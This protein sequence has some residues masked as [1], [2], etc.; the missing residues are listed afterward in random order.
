[1]S[2]ADRLSFL[3]KCF[4]NPTGG[5][6]NTAH[7]QSKLIAWTLL[8][9]ILFS[10]VT[11]FVVS[12]FNPHNDPVCNRYIIFI[13]GL[14]AFFIFAYILNCKGHY[15]ISSTI[16]VISASIAPWVSLY[17]DP[18]IFA[19]DFIPLTYIIISILLSSIFLPLYLTSTLVVFQLTGVTLVL[20]LS[21]AF[22]SFNWF[23]LLAFIF[24]ASF[25]S[26]LANGIIQRDMKQI[27]DQAH[28]L[29]LNER[30]L[31]EQ[32][33][34]D[35]LTNLFN[36]RYLEETLDREIKRATRQQNL[37]S[38]IMLD[39]DNFKTIN[40]SLGHTAGDITLKNLGELL[41]AQIRKSDIACRFGGDEFVLVL[42]DTAR[43][44]A[45]ERAKQLLTTTQRMNFPAEITISLGIAVFPEN[46]IDSKTLLKNADEA[47]IQ[48]KNKGGKCVV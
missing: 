37:L 46:G 27:S 17:I 43:E 3:L 8:L 48:A 32:S 23:S 44:T 36:R 26:I 1:M 10:I 7:H 15:I 39:V 2:V 21:P 42:P 47:L 19:G 20:I 12:I 33:T 24:L 31:R 9:V 30:L 25:F 34:R 40:D 38:V 14:V 6:Q 45:I 4:S 18:S 35:Y 16:L 13:S 29:K 11:I 22:E 41:N 28:Q 5:I